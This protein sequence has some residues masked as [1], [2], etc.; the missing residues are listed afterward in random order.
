MYIYVPMRRRWVYIC[1][2]GEKVGLYMFQ[3]EGGFINVPGK[4]RYVYICSREEKVGL[5]LFRGEKVGLYMFQGGEGRF[6]YVPGRR[7]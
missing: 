7:R 4:R 5:Y 3:G 6:K 1:S 2:R